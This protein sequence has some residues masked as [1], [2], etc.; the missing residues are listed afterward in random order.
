MANFTDD[1]ILR[2]DERFAEENI[3]FHARPFRA[4]VEILGYQFVLGVGGDPQVMEI[5]RAYERLIPEVAF[6]WPGMG[7]GLVSSVDR[8]KKVRVGVS[9]GRNQITVARGLGFSSDENWIAWCRG[10]SEILARSAFAFADMCDLVYGV[11]NR[12]KENSDNAYVKWGLGAGHLEVVANHL[13]Q[14]GKIDS[15]I[16]QSVCL[17][18][19][20]AIKGTLLH[21]GL[22]EKDLKNPKLFGH[23]LSKLAERMAEDCTHRDDPFLL[24]AVAKFPEYVGGRYTTTPLNRR[25]IIALALDAQFVA[26]SA[27]R[28][29][30]GVDM[31]KQVEEAEGARGNFFS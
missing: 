2:L 23:N 18:V 30:S 1:D 25:E 16:L 15:P 17:T 24:S 26:A 10:D 22:A 27:V 8:V 14:S 12:T 21:L 3:P 13:S 19:E 28:R 5:I 6:T 4:A 7:T 11:D 9:F 31:A 29:I 20:L